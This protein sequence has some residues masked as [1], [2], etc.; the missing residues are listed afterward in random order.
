MKIEITFYY[1]PIIFE[2]Y[3]CHWKI[4]NVRFYSGYEN[5]IYALLADHEFK[6]T[7]PYRTCFQNIIKI[8]QLLKEI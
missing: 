7:Q 2:Y 1:Q 5:S 3:P 8:K 4:N 6:L